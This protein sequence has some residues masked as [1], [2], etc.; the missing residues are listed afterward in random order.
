MKFWFFKSKNI[1]YVPSN[2]MNVMYFSETIL[3]EVESSDDEDKWK[4]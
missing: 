2:E 3:S 1:L 4:K